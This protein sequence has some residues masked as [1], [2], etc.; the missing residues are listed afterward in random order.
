MTN[1]RDLQENFISDC[2]SGDLTNDNLSMKNDICGQ[3]I[4]E[5]ARMQLYRDS[6]IGN[7][8][9][10]L[11]LTYPVIKDLV[12]DNFFD[13]MCHKYIEKHW[14]KSGNMNDYGKKFAEFIKDLEQTKSLPYLS[15]I[16]RLEWLFHLSSLADDKQQSD[17]SKFAQLT[18]E[19][20]S[21][22]KIDLHPSTMLI[23]S[24]YPILKIWEMCKENCAEKLDLKQGVNTL[25]VRKNLK[26]NLYPL[27]DNEM[28]FL[29][30]LINGETLMSAFDKAL[31]IEENAAAQ[32]FI[33]KH[34][35]IGTFCGYN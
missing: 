11:E 13:L 12:G 21:K 17:W 32:G 34:I 25:L 9:A 26:V 28:A 6:A 23:A 20:L 15:D 14:P 19:N 22:V 4:S 24:D 3:P 27:E 29:R 7:I 5:I 30:A 35:E 33:A 18:E 31:E 10:P 2:L 1:L 16:A 8:I